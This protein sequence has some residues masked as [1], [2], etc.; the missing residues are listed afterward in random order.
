MLGQITPLILTYNEAPNIRRTLEQLQWA[1]DIVV[2]DSF[3]E[4]GTLEILSEFPQVRVFQRKF[5]DF[6]SQC[7]FGLTET[8]I[9]SE[10]VLNLD[11]D[12]LLTAEL[13][14]EIESLEPEGASAFSTRFLYC[15]YGRRLRSGIYP[16]VTTL[17]Q[18]RKAHFVNDG[19]AH[20][21]V[22]EGVV[23][24]LAAPMLHDDRKSLRHW[25]QSQVR[26]TEQEAR[27]LLKAD[28][29]EVS[30]PDRIRRWRVLAPPAM[31]F[32]CLIIRGGIFDGWAGFYYAFQR[33]VAELMLSLY[34]L[35]VDLKLRDEKSVSVERTSEDEMEN[36]KWK[37]NYGK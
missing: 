30:W 7:N 9:Q 11:A 6:A 17:F 26:Y 33:T 20:R 14:R 23:K 32:Y 28:D 37:M 3:S 21:V 16:R 27:K 4:D 15:V 34:L 10:W 12:Y 29:V 24:N 13:I 31:L 8:G 25:F 18:R 36:E 5:D 2:V 1:R 19:H 35:E 22:L